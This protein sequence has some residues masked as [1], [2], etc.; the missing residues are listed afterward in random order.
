[1]NLA[2]R[3]PNANDGLTFRSLDDLIDH[4]KIKSIEYDVIFVLEDES[5]TQFY[6]DENTGCYERDLGDE[7]YRP[8]NATLH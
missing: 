5:L 2:Y 4:Y 7:W 6:Y 1:M 3:L 8:S